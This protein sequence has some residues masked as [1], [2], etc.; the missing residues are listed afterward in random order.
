MTPIKIGLS[1]KIMHKSA[2]SREYLSKATLE[3]FKGLAKKENQTVQN[4][5]N[6]KEIASH[7]IKEATCSQ[8]PASNSGIA[9]PFCSYLSNLPDVILS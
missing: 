6:T 8:R 3:R 1:H 5:S 7:K 9:Q 2:I 4:P